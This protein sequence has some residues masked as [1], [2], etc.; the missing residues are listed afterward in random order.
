MNESP[1]NKTIADHPHPFESLYKRLSSIASMDED[2]WQAF[3]SSV[4]V[5]TLESREILWPSGSIC[6]YLVF[7]KSGLIRSHSMVSDRQITSTFYP[8]ESL[9]YDDY[10]FL[11]QQP[12]TKTYEA[13]E[14]TELLLISR[15]RLLQLFDKYKVFERIGRLAV[16]QAHIKMIEAQ[17]RISQWSAED[18]Y[19]YL[20]KHQPDILQRVPQKIIASYLNISPEHLSRI[21]AK[22]AGRT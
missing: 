8:E 5:R 1:S 6:K 2:A 13:L 19:H 7:V 4:Q 20:Q 9:F 21:R 14:P 12:M 22:V 18:N 3:S 11:S 15:E 17:E 16:E 10:S